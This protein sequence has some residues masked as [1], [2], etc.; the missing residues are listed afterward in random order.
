[1]PSTPKP[2]PAGKK[3]PGRR[4]AAVLVVAM[5]VLVGTAAAYSVGRYRP[6]PSPVIDDPVEHFK[7]GSIG[8]DVENGLPLEIMKV[9]PRAFPQYLPKGAPHDFTAFGFVQEPGHAMP[10][11]FSMRQ[12]F[13]PVTGLTCSACHVGTARASIDE[14]PR[15]YLGMGAKNLDL[16]AYFQFLFASAS[17]ERFSAS[18]LVPLMQANGANLSVVDRIIYSTVVIPTMKAR[19]AASKKQFAPLFDSE[20]AFGPGRVDTFNP[21]KLN[22]L[23]ES[24]PNGIPHDELVGTAA[25]PSIWN[26]RVRIGMA[27]NWDGNAPRKKDRDMGAAFGAGATRKSIDVASIARISDWLRDLPAPAY[28][29]RID[30]S[31]VPR[32]SQVFAQRC[33]SCHA[34]GGA[35]TGKVDPLAT[36]RTDPYRHRSYTAQLNTLLSDY[37]KGYEWQI[38]DMAPTSGYANKPLDGVWAHAPYLHNGSVPSLMDLLTPEDKRNGGRPTFYV[39]HAVYDTVNVG[40]RTDIA[41]SHGRPSFLF[42]MRLP[43]NSNVGHSGPLYGTDLSDTDKRALVE[44]MKTLR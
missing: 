35:M 39:G 5:L 14:P 20:P 18:Y 29:W 4:I 28:P 23:G 24:Y 17:D 10:I 22:Q 11:G 8:G 3:H 2:T 26:Q 30:S 19:L 36:V 1:M 13:V 12:G 40:T 37:G 7:Y 38:K 15:T 42:D 9:L 41:D 43:G 34:L 21:Y 33:A 16:G 27:M 6:R 31:K 25:F 32:G 44:Y